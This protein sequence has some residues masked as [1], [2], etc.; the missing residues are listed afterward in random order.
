MK[1][2]LRACALALSC[3]S[4]AVPAADVQLIYPISS[5]YY[6]VLIP[7]EQ[8]SGLLGQ[9]P[10][11]YL[12]ARFDGQDWA[13]IPHQ[14]DKKDA[15]G[16]F[17]DPAGLTEAG[18]R[19]D[20][21]DELVFMA[22]DLGQRAPTPPDSAVFGL[23]IR[24][25]RTADTGW[26]YILRRDATALSPSD[27]DYVSYDAERD[28]IVGQTYRIGFSRKIPF[29]FESLQ[30]KLKDGGYAPDLLDSMK[31]KHSGKL[32][33]S[34]E[35]K[36]THRDYTS[37]I[38]F[39]KDGP[40]RVIRHTNNTVRMVLGMQSPAIDIDNVHYNYSF[41]MDTIMDFPFRIGM[42]FGD[43]VGIPTFD[44]L[45]SDDRPPVYIYSRNQREGIEVTGVM[46]ARKQAFNGL[47]DKEIIIVTRDGMVVSD[48]SIQ[49]GS[50]IQTRVNLTDDK[51]I[52]DPPE[53]QP[54]LYGD[55]GY[56][57]TGW[58]RL[59]SGAQHIVFRAYMLQNAE[60]SASLDLLASSPS[61]NPSIVS[62]RFPDVPD[63]QGAPA[64]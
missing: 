8:L 27:Q 49:Q 25:P 58:E 22:A 29:L 57:M 12:L 38:G 56:R 39:V 28:A 7:L 9:L 43:V 5:P 31:I 52:L 16:R 13:S 24:D 62:S 23:S 6:P 33:H 44:F 15:E 19:L 10:D 54:G 14:F 61:L 51:T 34:F 47:D 32:F 21:S 63:D 17:L 3:L 55:V 60:L 26:V 1:S 2:I 18:Q 59:G 37:R 20:V 53:E 4:S 41:I 35:F 45:V 46:D 50:P 36:R 30:W 11:G 64:P 42:F 40:V 48:M